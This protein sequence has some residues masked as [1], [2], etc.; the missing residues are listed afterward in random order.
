[1][2]PPVRGAISVVGVVLPFVLLAWTQALTVPWI[3]LA[4]IFAPYA[5]GLFV[6]L[7][8]SLFALPL[9]VY[10]G[11]FDTFTLDR[12]GTSKDSGK[13]QSD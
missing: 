1:V 11:P 13:A 12:S 10:R 7:T 3:I 9:I 8:Q 4:V 5:T 2:S 6:L